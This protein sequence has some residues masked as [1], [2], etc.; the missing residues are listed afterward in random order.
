LELCWII[1]GIV[2]KREEAQTEEEKS[3]LNPD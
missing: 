3:I 2:L 1:I